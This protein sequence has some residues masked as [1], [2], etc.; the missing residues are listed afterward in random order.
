MLAG[1]YYFF[2]SKPPRKYGWLINQVT[3]DKVKDLLP[4]DSLSDDF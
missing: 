3:G 2:A 1:T 4:I